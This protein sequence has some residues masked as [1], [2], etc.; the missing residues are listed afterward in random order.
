MSWE[1]FFELETAAKKS[2]CFTFLHKKIV[3]NFYNKKIAREDAEDLAQDVCVR[4]MQNLENILNKCQSVH[5]L[6]NYIYKLAKNILFDHLQKQKRSIKAAEIEEV[7]VETPEGV[8]LEKELNYILYGC[9]EKINENWCEVLIWK[10]VEGK[11]ANE[12]LLLSGVSERTQRLWRA[13]AKDQLKTCIE[14]KLQ[15]E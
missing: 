6:K 10:D 13:K 5:H 9:M 11:S 1:I 7:Y 3:H 15:N 2:Q 12:I 8:I 4:V 14:N